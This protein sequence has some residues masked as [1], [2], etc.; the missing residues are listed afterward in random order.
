MYNRFRDPYVSEP[1]RVVFGNDILNT[2]I[3][4]RT[5]ERILLFVSRPSPYGGPSEYNI[6]MYIIY[7]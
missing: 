6:Y 1:A 7:K 5:Y 2:R 3:L 4:Y